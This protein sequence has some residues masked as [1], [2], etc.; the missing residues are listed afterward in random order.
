MQ[1][2]ALTADC[3]E[4]L[5]AGEEDEARKVCVVPC[6]DAGEKCEDGSGYGLGSDR[7][8]EEVQAARVGYF[9]RRDWRVYALRNVGEDQF[10]SRKAGGFHVP[11]AASH[12][13]RR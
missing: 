13:V 10:G 8:F 5:L 3:E 2:L 12:L 9:F 4:L 1:Q 11:F 6:T 7:D